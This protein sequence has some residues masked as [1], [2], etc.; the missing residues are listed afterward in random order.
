MFDRSNSGFISRYDLKRVMLDIVGEK[1]SDAEVDLM[2]L[3]ADK[4]R[5]GKIDYE[6]FKMLQQVKT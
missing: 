4:D 2:M 6:E 5:N 1:V 3:E